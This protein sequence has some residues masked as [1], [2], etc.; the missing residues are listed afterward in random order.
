VSS[1]LALGI[2]I[3]VVGVIAAQSTQRA[4]SRAQE[5]AHKHEALMKEVRRHG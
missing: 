2:G 3:A 4:A 5:A 1:W